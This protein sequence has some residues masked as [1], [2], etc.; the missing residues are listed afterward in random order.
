MAF[1][2]ALPCGASI[3]HC[4][5]ES[6]SSWTPRGRLPR[7]HARSAPRRACRIVALDAVLFDCDGV[8]A[9]TER[10]AH[11]VAFNM[12]FREKELDADWDAELYGELLKTGGGKERMTRFWNE[13][14][15]PAAY[16]NS[17]DQVSL[18][19]GLHARKTELFM[20]LVKE[21]KVPLRDGVE[22]LVS[23]ALSSGTT[24]AVCSTS[25]EKAV[26]EIVALLGK[27]SASQIRIFAGDV[28]EKKKPR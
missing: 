9:E 25:N 8:L 3:P 12:A 19:K 5:L 10:D 13:V 27:E 26:S 6:R 17:E 15:W 22:R 28:V 16:S 18:V 24:V 20:N 1:V 11:R 23:Q 7:A 4:S 14:G 2:V 21:G